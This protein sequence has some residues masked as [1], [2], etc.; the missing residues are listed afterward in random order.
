MGPEPTV[1]NVVPFQGALY[2]DEPNSNKLDK[3]ISNTT[4][5]NGLIWSKDNKILYF[6]DSPTR[7]IVA[8]DYNLE[9]GTIGK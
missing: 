4:V 6:I 9:E 1:G 5:S 2:R 3:E 8:Y 7:K